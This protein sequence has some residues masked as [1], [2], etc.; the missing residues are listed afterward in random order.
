M[1]DKQL[2]FTPEALRQIAQRARQRGTGARGL[3]SII[4]ALMRD[5][6]FV[7]PEKSDVRQY[8]VTE[9]MVRRLD[10]PPPERG[11]LQVS[12]PEGD[13]AEAAPAPKKKP[14]AKPSPKRKSS[15]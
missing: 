13:E 3:R 11:L 1:D 4:E 12:E 6:L 15:A 10:L 5:V 2:E 14:K 8:V 7:L 9:E